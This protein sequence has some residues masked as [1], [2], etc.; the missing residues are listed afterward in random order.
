LLLDP[1]YFKNKFNLVWR[2]GEEL[3]T[4]PDGSRSRK[5]IQRTGNKS[6]AIGGEVVDLTVDA[7]IYTW[8]QPDDAD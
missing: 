1:V 3:Q 2:N 5:C 7:W 4:M 8:E 6:A